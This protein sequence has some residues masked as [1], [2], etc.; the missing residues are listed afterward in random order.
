[1]IKR[2]LLRLDALEDDPIAPVIG[3]AI[4]ALATF[5]LLLMPE[6]SMVALQ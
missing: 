4:L 6:P 1:M 5:V 2:L 3:V